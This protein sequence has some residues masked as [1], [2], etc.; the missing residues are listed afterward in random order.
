MIQRKLSIPKEEI[1][2]FFL[3]GPRQVG[4]TTFLK[5][6]LGVLQPDSGTIELDRKLLEKYSAKALAKKIAYVPQTPVSA[7]NFPVRELVLMGRYAHTG[8]LLFRGPQKGG[9]RYRHH[10]QPQCP[11][12]QRDQAQ[13]GLWGIC[14]AGT[15][16]PGGEL[17][18]AQPGE[19]AWPQP[20]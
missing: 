9:R 20:D 7:L 3:W 12:V 13:V 10:C 17:F 4:K 8:D 5:L 6:L 14:F 15:G 18:G 16:A 1:N 11:P 2:T 19:H